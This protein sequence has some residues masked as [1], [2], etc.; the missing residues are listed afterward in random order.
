MARRIHPSRLGLALLFSLAACT[1]S[2]DY[3]AV[4][5][6]GFI[7]NY[8]IAQAT[9]GIALKPMRDLPEG[10][11]IEATFENP[12]GGAPFVLRKEGPFNPTRI[13]LSTP[14]V[15]GIVEGRPYKV[16]VVLT[17]ASGAVLQAIEKTF[18]SDVDPK[19]MPQR[20]L[21]IGPGYQKNLDGSES[22]YPPSI[23]AAPAQKE[24]P[25]GESK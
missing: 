24:V 13:A 5:G 2:G 25:A 22:S 19:V 1:G 7:Y 17:D 16:S 11:V 15:Q 20:P 23:S 10:G 18:T 14:P 4:A 6:G 21:A 3:L 8:R 12:A 9:Y